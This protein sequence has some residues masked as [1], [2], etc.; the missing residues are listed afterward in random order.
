MA[1]IAILGN[2][3]G[4]PL[5]VL[6]QIAEASDLPSGEIGLLVGD[7]TLSD[8]FQAVSIPYAFDCSHGTIAGLE[9][10]HKDWDCGV[11][12]GSKWAVRQPDYPAYFAYL[13]G[14][15]FGHAKT[16]LTLPRLAAYEALSF[17]ITKV[18]KR[19]VWLY[20]E[21]PHEIRYNQHGLAV[22][23]ATYGL[24]E[25]WAEVERLLESGQ[26]G[27][28]ER[29]HK[30]LSLTP[31]LDLAGL[32]SELAE[33]LLPYKDQLI[34]KWQKDIEGGASGFAHYVK[35]DLASLWTAQ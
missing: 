22:A 7:P 13:L 10:H 24:D 21:W 9:D 25:L 23:D 26:E 8:D 18:S 11:I 31:R 27:D 6:G 16:V 5:E 28:E 15:E 4:V 35:D 17:D 19:D 34:A 2:P 14:H 3:E 12:I 1:N 30:V 33:F 32:Q 20:D 29:L